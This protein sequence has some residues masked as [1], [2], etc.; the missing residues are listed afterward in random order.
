MPSRRATSV[1]DSSGR[2]AEN[3]LRMLT[4]LVSAD[5]IRV[6]NNGTVV[7]VNGT[8]WA[9]QDAPI[10]ARR[11]GGQSGQAGWRAD[12]DA[13]AE[14]TGR[15]GGRDGRARARRRLVRAAGRGA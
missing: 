4:A 5:M 11:D 9:A 8:G 2:S 10:V 13:R 7:H 6:A 1:T 12:E 14:A 15:I 3:N